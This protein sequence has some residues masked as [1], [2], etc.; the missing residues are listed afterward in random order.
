MDC[1]KL[2]QE[3]YF[4]IY[5]IKLG[6]YYDITPDLKDREQYVRCAQENFIKVDVPK[7]G[8]IILFKVRG[9]LGHVGIYVDRERFLHTYAENTTSSLDRLSLWLSRIEGYYRW[10]QG[11]N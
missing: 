6:S 8:D 7:Y 1:Y 10:Q 2:V 9:I 3:F 5:K 11:S 4:R